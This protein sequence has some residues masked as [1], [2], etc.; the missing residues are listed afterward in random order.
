MGTPTKPLDDLT[1][2]QK[3]VMKENLSERA[4][5]CRYLDL[6]DDNT[7]VPVIVPDT[8]FKFMMVLHISV[9]SLAMWLMKR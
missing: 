3:K 1:N 6:L 8:S 7:T 9:F 4:S 5:E 2:E